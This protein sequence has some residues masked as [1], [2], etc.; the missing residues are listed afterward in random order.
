MKLHQLTWKYLQE[1]Y[2]KFAEGLLK[3]YNRCNGFVPYEQGFVYVI[4]AVGSNYYK[5]GKS[6]NP[7][8]RLLQIAPQMPFSTRY[9]KVWRSNFMSLAESHLHEWFKAKRAN[10]E[11]FELEAQ[12]L[13]ILFDQLTEFNVKFAYARVISKILEQDREEFFRFYPE[14]D[15]PFSED[16]LGASAIAAIETLFELIARSQAPGV[17]DYIQSMIDSVAP[18]PPEGRS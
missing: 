8:R 17:P 12:D 14:F 16:M 9:V 10:G 15:E 1:Q 3:E 2:P 11:W 18:K 5:I 7:D 6:I 4:H 13:Y